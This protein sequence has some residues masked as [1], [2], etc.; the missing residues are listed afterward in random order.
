M[1]QEEMGACHHVPGHAGLKA[2]VV[3]VALKQEKHDQCRSIGETN[4]ILPEAHR[5]QTAI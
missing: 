4:A 1:E 5:Y 2:T 3:K